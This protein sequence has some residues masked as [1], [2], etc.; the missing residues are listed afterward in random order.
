M[1]HRA[2]HV[3]HSAGAIRSAIGFSYRL[4]EASNVKKDLIIAAATADRREPL[5][6][7]H[8]RSQLFIGI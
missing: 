7:F 6:Q 2:G 5:I 3:H 1:A 4:E 8:K